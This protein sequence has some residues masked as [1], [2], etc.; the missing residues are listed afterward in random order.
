MPLIRRPGRRPGPYRVRSARR[1]AATLVT[2]LSILLPV[3]ATATDRPATAV[4]A[5]YAVSEQ[6]SS[7]LEALGTVRA[8]EA[9]T[10]SSTVTETVRDVLFRDGQRVQA[11]DLLVHLEDTEEQAELAAAQARLVEQ[12]NALERSQRLLDR[13]LGARAEVEDNRAR[14]QQIQA[15]IEGIKARLA[16]HRIHAP[17]DGIVGF[18]DISN[19]MLVSPGTDLVTL[20]KLDSVKVDFTVPARHVGVLSVG[21]SVMASTDAF[22]ERRFSGEVRAIR[23]RVD[24]ATRS[25]TIRARID[26]DEGLLRPGMLMRTILERD[27][28]DVVAVPESVLVPQGEHQYLFVIDDETDRV[29]R[30]EVEIGQRRP[31]WVEVA[32]GLQGGELLVRHGVQKVRDGV[33]V[34]VLDVA[35]EDN[36]VREILERHRDELSAGQGDG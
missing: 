28:R 15:E 34:R 31:G 22:P 8:D 35:D 5:S 29:E 24:A 2:V 1:A 9:V 32:D 19:G 27:R 7:P 36:P 25:I 13:N 16:A 26:N 10:L 17:F 6:W 11:G 14:V 18:R 12:R 21:Q 23:P 30:R 3:V 20:D 4:I 33:A